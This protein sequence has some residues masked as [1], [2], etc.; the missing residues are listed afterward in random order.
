MLPY[1]TVRSREVQ[2]I[3]NERIKDAQ[4][5]EAKKLDLS[6]IKYVSLVQLS[7]VIGQF[8][9]LLELNLSQNQLTILPSI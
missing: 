1:E 8:T 4:R 2:R 9:H 3:V 6:A 5:S 7:E